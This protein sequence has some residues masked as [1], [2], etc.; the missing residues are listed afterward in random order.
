MRT[1]FGHLTARGGMIFAAVLSLSAGSLNAKA[2]ECRITRPPELFT[3]GQATN[4][5][6]YTQRNIP[7]FFNFTRQ[8]FAYFKQR[9]IKRPRGFYGISNIL[10]GMYSTSEGLRRRRLF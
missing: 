6:F 9:V 10:H 2:D 7:C 3:P 5:T 4:V 8:P 1:L